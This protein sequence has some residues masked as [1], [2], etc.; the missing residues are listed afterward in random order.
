MRA[1][2]PYG[3]LALFGILA[4]ASYLAEICPRSPLGEIGDGTCAG[5]ELGQKRILSKL[6]GAN[7]DWEGPEHCVN[8]TCIF[9][10]D[11]IGDGIV[12]ITS[13][14]NA[15]IASNFPVTTNNG[16]ATLPFHAAEVPG[17]GV[18]IVADRKI[19]KGETILIRSPTMMVQTAPHVGM[20][21]GIRGVLYDLAVGKLPVRGRE[22]F[23]GQMGKDVYDKIETNCF[24]MYI[25]GANDSGGHLGCYPEV[26]RFNHD[27]RPNIHYR[28]SN[29]THITVAARDI[30][31]GQELSISYIELMLPREERR[32]RLRSW[33]F[34]CACSHCSMSDEEVAASDARIYRIE[35]LETALENFN[36]TIVTA[37]TGAQLAELYER[38]RLDVYL[39]RVYTRAALNFAL[40]GEEKKAQKYALA[41]VEA[42]EREL[43]PNAADAKAM[44]ILAENP[45]EHWTWGKRRRGS[46]GKGEGR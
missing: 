30:E 38:E 4:R 3:Y 36:Q 21:S 23:M 2:E 12:L 7:L 35:E 24:Q 11:H 6:S 16:A 45:K 42:V 17:K 13:E 39:G 20:E 44:R 1:I 34:E 31:P 29:M 22:L 43:G 46:L 27:C 15:K 19:R 26:S 37:E 18:G 9:S 40:F 33:G 8:E 41:A 5:F 32:S 28:I 25:D 14:I 10:N